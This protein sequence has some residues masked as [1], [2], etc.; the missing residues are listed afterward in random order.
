MKMESEVFYVEKAKEE[1]LDGFQ[2]LEVMIMP[3][4]DAEKKQQM[5]NEIERIREEL[6]DEMGPACHCVSSSLFDCYREEYMLRTQSLHEGY[7]KIT[8]IAGYAQIKHGSYKKGDILEE[9]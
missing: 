1:G 8:G 9:I 7:N 4:E 2:E 6:L 5:W 3:R